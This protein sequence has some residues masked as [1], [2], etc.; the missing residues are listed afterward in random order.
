MAKEYRVQGGD[1]LRE[2]TEQECRVLLTTSAVGRIG[3]S[4]S[5]LPVIHPVNYVVDGDDI[6]IET[7]DP[8]KL[9][10]ALDE[11][12]VCFEIDGHDPVSHEGWSVLVTGRAQ[13]CVEPG[14]ADTPVTAWAMP[15]E[16]L[17]IRIRPELITGRRIA[18]TL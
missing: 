14:L 7:G 18:H 11:Q 1:R 6:V 3:L 4:V 12:V 13:V 8:M 17:Y 5:A 2:L 15:R 10:A 9:R 16:S